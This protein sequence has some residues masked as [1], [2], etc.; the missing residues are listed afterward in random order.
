[1][2]YPC[3][4]GTPRTSSTVRSISEIDGLAYRGYSNLL[5]TIQL[6]RS[7]KSIGKLQA[8]GMSGRDLVLQVQDTPQGRA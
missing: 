2:D 1:M 5:V 4:P 3:M 7:L 8:Q 6:S